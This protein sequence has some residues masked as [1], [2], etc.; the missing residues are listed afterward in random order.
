MADKIN[1][2][3]EEAD[4]IR[5]DFVTDGRTFILRL[6]DTPLSGV[7]TTP[8][9]AFDNLLAA[10]SAAGELPRRLSALAREQAGEQVRARIIQLA[11]IALIVLGVAGG[12]TVS[13]AAMAPKVAATLIDTTIASFDTWLDTMPA[14]RERKLS[15]VLTRVDALTHDDRDA[16][17]PEPTATPSAPPSK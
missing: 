17:R 5:G 12:A 16:G 15:A 2:Q 3:V 1:H 10:Q 9:E 6:A 8:Q 11:M 7:G 4:V 14:E 13:A